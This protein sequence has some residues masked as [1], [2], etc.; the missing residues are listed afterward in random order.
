GHEEREV[1]GVHQV[2]GTGGADLAQFRRLGAAGEGEHLLSVISEQDLAAHAA[3]RAAY[4]GEKFRPDVLTAGGIHRHLD[5]AK[6]R[7]SRD[8]G[9]NEP[10]AFFDDAH[11]VLIAFLSIVPPSY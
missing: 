5:A 3:H 7:L 10:L 9:L 1:L 11:G 8:A 6:D 4:R 2:V